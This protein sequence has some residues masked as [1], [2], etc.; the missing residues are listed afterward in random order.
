M[1]DSL[2]SIL[3]LTRNGMETLPAALERIAEL[4]ES[5]QK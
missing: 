2:V 1:R 5:A 3:I 4:A